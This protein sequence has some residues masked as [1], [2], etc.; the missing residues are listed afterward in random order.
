MITRPLDLASRLA[1]PPRNFDL[2]FYVNVPLI[3]LFFSLFYSR[4]VLAPGLGMDFSL[5]VIAGADAGAR[6]TDIVIA[7]RSADMILVEETVLKLSQL[8]P[9]LMQQARGRSGLRLLVQV[10]AG[11][12]TKDTMSIAEMAKAAGFEV[13]IAAEP[14]AEP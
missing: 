3:V 9:W 12:P 11:L 5:P 2:F 7:V 14:P 6:P 13:Q 8:Q 10:N 1:P 4:F